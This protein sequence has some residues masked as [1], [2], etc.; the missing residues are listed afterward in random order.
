[1]H[2]LLAHRRSCLT[3]LPAKLLPPA[4]SPTMSDMESNP[5]PVAA[6]APLTESGIRALIR[7]E[8]QVALRPT[9]S[10]SIARA[11]MSTPALSQS[12]PSG[13]LKGASPGFV[14]E[15]TTGLQPSLQPSS[16]CSNALASYLF[17]CATI[18]SPVYRCSLLTQPRPGVLL[19]HQPLPPLRC[20]IMPP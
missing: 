2:M 10:T 14:A 13:K 11:A 9:M 6:E 7:E 4:T 20:T 8:I 19:Y 1:M 5:Q 17:R 12:G 16:C 15:V 18:S 3:T